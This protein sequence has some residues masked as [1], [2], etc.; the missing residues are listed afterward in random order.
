MK[1]SKIVIATKILAI[2]A[3]CLISFMGVYSQKLNKMEN[4][5]KD[6][7]LSK[8]LTGYRE[9]I[10]KISDANKVMDKDGK[11]IGDTDSYTDESIKENEYKKSEEKVNKDEFKNEENYE[12]IRKI[13]IKRLETL[14]IE[15]FSVNVST[16]DGTVYLQ[17]PEDEM[18]DKIVSNIVETGKIEVKDSQDGTVFLTE[19]NLNKVTSMYANQTNGTTVYLELQFDKEGA[20]KLKDL[21]RNEYKTIEKTEEDKTEAET[22]EDETEENEESAEEN[23]E[24]TEEAKEEEQKKITLTI[25]GNKVVETSFDEPIE[26]GKIDLTMG[27]SSKD[28]ETISG[29][30]QSTSMVSATLNSGVIPLKYNL[31]EN[32]YVKTEISKDE[33]KNIVKISI[34]VMAV[35]FLFMIL[36]KGIKS[37]LALIC[38]VGFIALYLLLL[39]YTNVTIAISGIIGIIAVAFINY[40][41]I[42]KMFELKEKDYNEKYMKLIMKLIP[43]F[44]ISIVFCFIKQVVL[45]SAGMVFF[46]GILLIAIYNF[47]IT[48]KLVN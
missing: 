19:K 22:S 12:N 28:S 3:I 9:I 35:L 29:Y 40:M 13:I 37:I 1:K 31:Q 14:G 25:S 4:I 39:R 7:S 11:E 20:E 5:V 41:F 16:N 33:I 21:S 45:N 18:T 46:W 43:V 30:L 15:D 42:W 27:Q 48:K 23:K 17:V 36:K 34:V 32:R 2:I 24:T 6:F 38:Y 8:D 44:A 47:L 10:F 26:N